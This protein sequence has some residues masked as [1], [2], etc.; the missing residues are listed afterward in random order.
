MEKEI[1]KD[2]RRPTPKGNLKDRYVNVKQSKESKLARDIEETVELL[3]VSGEEINVGTLR[4][5]LKKYGYDDEYSL[6]VIRE[7]AEDDKLVRA[8]S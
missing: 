8:R 4:E 2:Y 5:G 3:P 1:R 6:K 7:T